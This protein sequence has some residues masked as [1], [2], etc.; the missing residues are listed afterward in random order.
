M[1][2]ALSII[3][4]LCAVI[5]SNSQ[6]KLPY[7][8]IHEAPEKFTA[9]A[10]VSRMIDGLGFRFYWASE[11]LR[12]EDLSFK[13][14]DEARTSLETIQHIFGLTNMIHNCV[15][16][17][18]HDNGNLKEMT[19]DE[20]RKSILVR[21]KESSDILRKSDD[22]SEFKI[23]MGSGDRKTELPFWNQI[24][25]PI[26]DALWHTGQVVSFRRSSGNPYNSKASVFSGKVRN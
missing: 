3:A 9:G 17:K 23:V 10:T 26:S 2:S 18:Q 16:Q 21:L 22:I 14:S 24:N 8:E 11:G 13:P 5:T 1:K 19:F 20:L 7:Y 6:E 15:T 12:N 4:I 25:G